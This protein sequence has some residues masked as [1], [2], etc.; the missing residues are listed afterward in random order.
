VI[1]GAVAEH[2]GDTIGM[3]AVD[4]G[5]M[6]VRNRSR[7][8][9]VLS[10]R[11]FDAPI[12]SIG[13]TEPHYDIRCSIAVLPFRKMAGPE[14]GYFAD[15]FADNIIHALAALK[16][17][18]VISRGSTLSYG[19]SSIDVRAIGRELGV[20][21]VLYGSVQRSGGRIRI[22]TELSDAESGEVI[23]SDQYD[24]DIEN[25][26]NLQDQIAEEVVKTIE[27]RVRKRELMRAL[28]KHPQNMTAYDLVLQALELLNRLENATFSGARGLLQRAMT[29]DPTYSPAFSYAAWWHSYRI[30]QEWSTDF[31]MDAAEAARL[32]QAAIELDGSD[33]LALA[34]HGHL[35]SFLMKD[36]DSALESFDRAVVACPNSA[37]AW[38]LKGAT[39]CFIGDG[40]SALECANNGLRLSPRDQ[41]IFFAEHILAQAHYINGDFDEAVLWSQRADKHNGQLTSNLR[42]LVA[43]LVATGRIEEAR[44]VAERHQQIAPHFRL[45]S[46]AGRSPMSDEIKKSRIDKLRKAGMPD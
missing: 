37:I 9:R 8:I 20:R 44:G 25:L 34:I 35:R 26:F 30:G 38:T 1:S 3:Q 40:P 4:L 14:G 31:A 33:A 17:L 32:A 11:F 46:W 5:E 2:I 23:R 22:G 36:F 18:F 7:P 12:A 43:S 41:H 16:E 19:G 28:R 42:T 24:G 27:P 39:H 29:L 21:Y 45:L 6:Q 15:G 10:L 13:E